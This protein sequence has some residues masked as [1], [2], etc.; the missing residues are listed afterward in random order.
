MIRQVA[1]PQASQNVGTPLLHNSVSP[2][3]V[4]CLV[5]SFVK[6]YP[7]HMYTNSILCG[8]PILGDCSTRWQ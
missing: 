3:V 8:P 6:S 4:Q 1:F 7:E 2:P 5:I